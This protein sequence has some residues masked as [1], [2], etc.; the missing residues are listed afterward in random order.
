MRHV[1]FSSFNFELR[2]TSERRQNSIS[3]VFLIRCGNFEIIS[4][5]IEPEVIQ[6]LRIRRK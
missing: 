1:Q 5:L 2:V 3:I 4:K 6:C